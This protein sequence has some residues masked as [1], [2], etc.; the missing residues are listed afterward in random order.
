M[1]ITGEIS[2]G[3]LPKD[4][5]WCKDIEFR[6]DPIGY[7]L[8]APLVRLVEGCRI[9]WHQ[10]D[11]NYEIR[12]PKGRLVGWVRYDDDDKTDIENVSCIAIARNQTIISK[13]E[14]WGNGRDAIQQAVEADR[15]MGEKDAVG[16][17]WVAGEATGNLTGVGGGYCSRFAGDTTRK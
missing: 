9:K 6:S 15:A 3:K 1:A 4:V 7:K 14:R 13:G 11:T 5:M 17:G 10:R 12:N 16:K 8:E 2:Y